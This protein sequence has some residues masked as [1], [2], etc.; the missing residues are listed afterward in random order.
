MDEL[1]SKWV[2]SA[3]PMA[4][5]MTAAVAAFGGGAWAQG[6]FTLDSRTIYGGQLAAGSGITI[7]GWGSGTCEESTY[8][9]YSGSRSLKITPKDLYAGG[10]IDFAEPMDLTSS[11]NDPDVYLQLVTRFAGVQP[12]YDSWAAG[13]TTP[14]AA[15][16]YGGTTR[17]GKQV[18]RVRLMLCLEGGPAVECQVDVSSFRFSEGGWMN[19]SFPL[20]VLKGKLDLPTY[21]IRRLV[22][23]GDGTEPFYVGEI[24][25]IRD[26]TPL[27]VSAGEGKEVARNYS[28]VFRG[29]GETGASAVKYSWDFNKD[30]GI[31]EESVG[32]IISH[33]FA[34]VGKYVVTLTLHDVFGLK[35]PAVS[36]AN[37]KV[38]E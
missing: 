15:D 26:T 30:D 12:R 3:I 20:A 18:R 27:R 36:T 8:N 14:S 35:K 22:I 10:R 38:N 32:D 13:L 11:F 19:V 21:K 25:T 33:R 37:V 9:T 17:T 4:L 24:R 1:L 5:V 6:L 16:L 34:T 2:R 29:V 23:T 31:Q 28:V 7:G